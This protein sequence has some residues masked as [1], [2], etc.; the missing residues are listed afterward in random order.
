MKDDIHDGVERNI[1]LENIC[2]GF[3]L[4]LEEE[5]RLLL[6][7]NDEELFL[8]P[9]CL[10]LHFVLAGAFE[11]NEAVRDCLLPMAWFTTTARRYGLFRVGI[12]TSGIGHHHVPEMRTNFAVQR[13]IC[14]S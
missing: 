1:V 11:E 6:V 3:E 4:V 5:Q 2:R 8:P 12:T 14:S 13:E 7:V 9:V 10:L